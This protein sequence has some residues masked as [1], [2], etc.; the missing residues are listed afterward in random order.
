MT[1]GPVLLRHQGNSW[2]KT[3]EEQQSSASRERMSLVSECKP[4]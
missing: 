1:R 3:G 2:I 4:I